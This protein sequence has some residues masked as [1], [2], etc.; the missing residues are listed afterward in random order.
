MD[1]AALRIHN[2]M[3]TVFLLR[4]RREKD[5]QLGAAYLE[6]KRLQAQ[7][8][9]ATYPDLLRNQRYEAA[10]GFF[11]TELYGDQDYAQRDRQFA[12]I[13]GTIAR[14]F[15]ESVVETAASLAEVHALTEKLDDLVARQWLASSTSD[16]ATRYVAC[17]RAVG[18]RPARIEQLSTVL[19]LGRSLDRLTHTR[20]LRTLL[21]MMRA[22]AN[23]AGLSALQNFLECGFD[24]FAKMKDA[25][26][27]LG[28]VEARETAWIAS[29]F[30]QDAVSCGTQLRQLLVST[31]TH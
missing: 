6:V 12:R 23:A 21:K 4:Q 28:M 26:G 15:P 10:A 17:W 3:Q 16:P 9:R 18:D 31:E 25:S 5:P 24:A 19:D 11:L 13:A 1:S 30:D 7:R 20:G 2:A 8:F 14:I 22:P 29:L 27:F